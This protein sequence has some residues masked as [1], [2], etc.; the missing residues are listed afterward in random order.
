MDTEKESCENCEFVDRGHDEYCHEVYNISDRCP[1]NEL[2]LIFSKVN[3]YPPPFEWTTRYTGCKKFKEDMEYKLF[4]E[5][6]EQFI[7]E[8]NENREKRMKDNK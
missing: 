4:K 1:F 8:L 7:R 6:T 2:I 5:E 3:Q